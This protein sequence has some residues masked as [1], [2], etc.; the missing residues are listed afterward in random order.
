[1]FWNFNPMRVDQVQMEVTQRDQFRNDV[2][3]LQDTLVRESIQNSSDAIADDSNQVRVRFSLITAEDGVIDP[4]FMKNLFD[5]QTAH[6]EAAGLELSDTHI[7][8]RSALVI[9]DFGTKGLTGA[10]DNVDDENFSDFWRRH[11]KSHKK[12][13]H[14][15]RHGLGK[16]VYSLTSQLGSFFGITLREGDAQAYLMGQTVLNIHRFDGRDYNPHSFFS[17]SLDMGELGALP[18]PIIEDQHLAKFREN[19]ALQRTDEPGLSI[20]IPFPEPNISVDEMIRI[21]IHNYFIPILRDKL[22]LEFGKV[23]LDSSTL[24]SAAKTYA[25]TTIGNN[26]TDL[27]FSFIE[28]AN[29]LPED[30][31]FQVKK[32]WHK[33]K[34]LKDTAFSEKEL[35]TLRKIFLDG[36]LIGLT[37]PIPVT[38]KN[39]KTTETSFKLYLQHNENIEVGQDF[40]VRAGITI[41][42]EAKFKERK[43]FGML[44]AEDDPIAGFLGNAEDAAHTRWNGQAEKLRR[45]YRNGPDTLRAVRTSLVELYDI[46]SRTLEVEDD[47]VLLDFL[48][49]PGEVPQKKNPKPKPGPDNS[50][51]PEPPPPKEKPYWIQTIPGGFSLKPTVNTDNEE[52][53][54]DGTVAAGYDLLKGNPIKKH[55]PDD[56]D[57]TRTGDALITVKGA[58]VHAA[59]ANKLQFTLT[60]KDFEITVTGLDDNRDLVVAVS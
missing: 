45:D 33:E 56:F 24:R 51:K 47:S 41:P 19:F 37:L 50:P 15:G 5:G 23:R 52:F 39:G 9:E 17:K 34:R 35:E 18:I 29:S 16:I 55:T 13:K 12:G 59:A 25:G 2:V 46:L 8:K 43:A 53:P 38:S 31:L 7:S 20:I 57:F 21:A 48:W 54:F 22:V 44:I 10:V 6:A 40:Y 49:T 4:Q 36:K 1:M 11:G 30:Q 32:G 27:L 14:G 26:D 58:D 28:S 60:D 3:G 42:G